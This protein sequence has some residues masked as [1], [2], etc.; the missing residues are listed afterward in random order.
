MIDQ[1]I[2]ENEHAADGET[3]ESRGTHIERIQAKRR[4]RMTCL[5]RRYALECARRR[6]SDEQLNKI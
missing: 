5:I 1:Y 3:K 2:C 4:V 6:M